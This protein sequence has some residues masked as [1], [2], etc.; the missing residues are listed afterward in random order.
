MIGRIYNSITFRLSLAYRQRVGER[1]RRRVLNGRS[2]TAPTKPSADFTLL[3]LV[4][5]KQLELLQ[6]SLWSI[7]QAWTALPNLRVVSDGSIDPSQ[8]STALRWWPQPVEAL[9][10]ET[11]AQAHTDRGRPLLQTLANDN[12]LARKLCAILYSAELGPTL[13]CDSDLLWFRGSPPRPAD[14]VALKLAEDFM[15][16]FDAD[17]FTAAGCEPFRHRPYL[18]SGV[19]FAA[20]DVFSAAHLGDVLPWAAE[21]PKYFTEQTLLAYA[22]KKLGGDHWTRQ[23]IHLTVD[24]AVVPFGDRDYLHTA[25]ARHYVGDVRHW[26][27]RDVWHLLRAQPVQLG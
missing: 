20:G 13:F 23:Q 11:I 6:T 24:D 21:H 19:V 25:L 3:S 4:G 5:A 8:I 17:L 18:N 7:G 14:A 1:Y 27:W 2:W 16:S 26:F 12:L 9:R 22:C 15:P 10:W